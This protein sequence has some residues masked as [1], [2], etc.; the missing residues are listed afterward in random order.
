MQVERILDEFIVDFDQ[1]FMTFQLAEP[2]DP[3]ILLVLQGWIVGKPIDFVLL[4]V[5]L[6]IVVL[7][8]LHLLGLCR[9]SL[10]LHRSGLLVKSACVHLFAP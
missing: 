3:A 1:K 6:A 9:G 4:L 5:R 7:L 2:L 10:G 8:H